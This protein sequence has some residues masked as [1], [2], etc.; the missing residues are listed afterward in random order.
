MDD[1]PHHKI[2]SQQL[3]LLSPE[4]YC[5]YW[6]VIQGMSVLRA[7]GKGQRDGMVTNVIVEQCALLDEKIFDPLDHLV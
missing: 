1:C 5:R 4:T 7:R 6:K 3:H 2:G